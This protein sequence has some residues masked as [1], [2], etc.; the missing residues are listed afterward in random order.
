V[1]LRRVKCGFISL[2]PTLIPSHWV[3]L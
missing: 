1:R 2:T 3:L